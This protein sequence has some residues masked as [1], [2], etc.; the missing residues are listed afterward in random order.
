MSVK[1]AVKFYEDYIN[2]L[3]MSHTP[4]TNVRVKEVDVFKCGE[5]AYYYV[6]INTVSYDGINL[7]YLRMEDDCTSSSE[8]YN[9]F[10]YSMGCM[11]VTDEVDY[12]YGIHR[13]FKMTEE[14]SDSEIISFETAVDILSNAM[15]AD[16][17]V[18]GAELLYVPDMPAD[19][20][21][22]IEDYKCR[23]SAKWKL[24]LYSESDDLY[25]HCYVNAKDGKGF[26][27]FKTE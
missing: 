22:V 2:T 25:Y 5:N 19:Q 13:S 16:Y 27:R 14:T 18:T 6:F 24:T 1:D 21:V 4:T 12:T 9:K 8:S 17:V 3:P 11:V 23:T 26:E 10:I 15:V 7:S 20:R